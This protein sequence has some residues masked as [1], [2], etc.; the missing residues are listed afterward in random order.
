[1]SILVLGGAGYIGSHAVSQLI[2]N[3][4]DVVVVDNLL[5]GHKEAINKK[6]KF[7]KGD[8]RDKEFLKDVFEKESF[9]A[10]IHFAANSLVGESMVDPLKYFNNNVQGTQTLLE[11]MNEFNV[12]NIVFSSTAATYGEPKQIPITEDMETCPTNPYGET[13]LT[14]EKIMKWCDKAYGIKYVSLRYFNVAGARKGGA[15]GEDHN[16]ETHLIPIVLQVALGK[17]DFITIYGEDYDTEDGTC[18]RDYIHVEDLIEAHILAMKHLLNGG[19]SDIFNLGSSQGFSVKEIIE[20]ARK[21]TKHPIPAQI[22][23]RRA[24]DP[25]K[26]VASSDKA[27]KILGWNPSRTNITKIIEDAWVWHTNNK[28]GYNK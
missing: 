15:I 28:S 22:G 9:E 17:R 5:T 24:G 10:V 16:P 25:S 12:K 23:E 27:R 14:M 18:V 7:Y 19:D 13:K 1:M 4:Y 3:D 8:I 11:V 20:S 21:V 6:A 2:D 26:L